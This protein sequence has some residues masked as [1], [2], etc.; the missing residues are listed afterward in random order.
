LEQFRYINDRLFCEGTD[1]EECAARFGT[2]LY[3][4]SRQSVIDHCRW[5]ESAFGNED[6][7]SCYALK[8]NSNPSIL[9]ILAG[10]GIGADVGSAGELAL[11]LDAGFPADRITFSGVGKRDDEIAGA[12][13]QDILSINAES[14]EELKVISDIAM[15]LHKRA[16]VSV[17]VNFDIRSETHSYL[18]TGRKHNKFGVDASRAEE[19]FR[20]AA[21]LPGV[22]LLGV[23]SH[24]GSQITSGETFSAAARAIIELIDRLRRLGISLSHLNFGGGFGVRYRDYVTHPGLPLELEN[25]ESNLTTVSMLKEV[26]PILRSARCKILIQPGR[27]MVAHAG[28]LIT[29]VLYKKNSGGKTFV[30]VDA[31]MNDL[32]RPSLYQSYHQIVPLDLRPGL[33]PP[34]GTARAGLDHEVV[35]VVGPLCETGDFFAL[36]RTIPAVERGEYLAVLCTGAYGYVLSSNYN[37]RPKP[38]EVLVDAGRSEL[39]SDRES[40]DK[41]FVKRIE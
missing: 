23:H 12:I 17:R 40:V 41:L 3:L 2:P 14:E 19:V 24:I 10:E 32:I 26:L 29:K 15:E 9:R 36:D 7:L 31:G 37:G 16:R 27:S 34:G 33:V 38:A 18:T 21:K 1:L 13:Q 25:P 39:I 4:Y 20:E 5:I 8:A 6:H 28:V 22:E 11:A 35:D 30:I